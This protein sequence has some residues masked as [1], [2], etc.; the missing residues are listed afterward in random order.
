M[1][2]VILI[3]FM[4]LFLI[5]QYEGNLKDKIQNCKDSFEETKV[6]KSIEN[7]NNLFGFVTMVFI[8][9]IFYWVFNI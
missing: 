7:C 4:F 1:D 9:E 8:A 3:T 2:Y 5:K 6:A